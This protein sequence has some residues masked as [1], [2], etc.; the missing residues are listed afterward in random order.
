MLEGIKGFED[1]TRKS[2]ALLSPL[3][4]A[5][6]SLKHK[7]AHVAAV[8]RERL[9]AISPAGHAE[10]KEIRQAIASQP[11]PSHWK[12]GSFD[13]YGHEILCAQAPATSAPQCKVISLL[14]LHSTPQFLSEWIQRCNDEGADITTI[15]LAQNVSAEENISH[16]TRKTGRETLLFPHENIA[17]LLDDEER[18]LILKGHSTGGLSLLDSYVREALQY[19]KAGRMN[20]NENSPLHKANLIILENPYVKMA[21]PSIIPEWAESSVCKELMR[22]GTK[23]KHLRSN[24]TLLGKSYG[25]FNV[26][27][28]GTSIYSSDAEPLCKEVIDLNRWGAAVQ[29]MAEELVKYKGSL[30]SMPPIALYISQ[31]D[32]YASAK[33]TQKLAD[34]LEEAG[35]P[36]EVIEV[37]SHEHTISLTD[38][39]VSNDMIRRAKEAARLASANAAPTAESE[40]PVWARPP[41][42]RIPPQHQGLHI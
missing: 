10:M 33:S 16:I 23:N 4:E 7:F 34:T 21:L 32:P 41:Q 30:P 14:G 25:I 38:P 8:T 36:I 5:T 35:L 18:P 39:D 24:E 40:P 9:H 37:K 17:H 26:L 22:Y 12:T 15:R 29:K 6:D 42:H 28:S 1:L 31:N 3:F 27:K 20:G 19:A 11:L 13:V 2:S